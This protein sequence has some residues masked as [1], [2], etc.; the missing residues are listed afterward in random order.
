MPTGSPMPVDVVPD[1][2][3]NVIITSDELQ[4]GRVLT[5]EECTFWPGPRYMPHFR[6]CPKAQQHRKSR[7]PE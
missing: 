2:Q 3:G 6:S 5:K 1:R 7:R 4:L